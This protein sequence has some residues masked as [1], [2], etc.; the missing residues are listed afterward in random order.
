MKQAY[1]LRLGSL[2]CSIVFGIFVLVS[3]VRGQ[4]SLAYHFPISDEHFVYSNDWSLTELE[5]GSVSLTKEGINIVFFDSVYLQDSLS[6]D[7]NSHLGDVMLSLRQVLLGETQ[8][9]LANPMIEEL[10][11]GNHIARRYDYLSSD[12]DLRGILIAIEFNTGRYGAANLLIP[13]S[14][15]DQALTEALSIV[16]SFT[17]QVPCTVRTDESDT[18]QVRVGPGTNRG[19]LSFLPANIDFV[20]L[21]QVTLEDGSNWWQLDRSEVAPTKMAAE[22]WVPQDAVLASG[23]C[24]TIGVAPIPPIIVLPSTDSGNGESRGGQDGGGDALATLINTADVSLCLGASSAELV[25][26]TWDAEP[27]IA[28]AC[29]RNLLTWQSI[30]LQQQAARSQ[31]SLCASEPAASELTAYYSQNW[32]LSDVAVGYLNLGLSLK[33]SGQSTLAGSAFNRVI[34]FYS[35]AWAWDPRGWFWSVKRAAIEE[36]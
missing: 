24:D 6:L 15:F 20:V 18:V 7:Q 2:L 23:A 33:Q 13:A 10:I 32:A 17:D 30:A 5:D 34:D 11:L 27:N 3:T 22:A 35:C 21:G 29:V 1:R 9:D 12:R 36:I 25:A 19:I 26:Q 16:N 8:I 4:D 14:D 31:A 28:A